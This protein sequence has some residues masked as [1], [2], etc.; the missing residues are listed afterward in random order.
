MDLKRA[1][2]RVVR[3]WCPQ[4]QILADPF[5]LV[6]DANRRLDAIRRLEQAEGRTPIPRWPLVKGAEHLT[7]RQQEQLTQIQAHWPALAQL[8]HLKEDLRALL[9]SATP[10]E[11]QQRWERWLLNA[12]ACDHAEGAVWARTLRRWRH[13]ILGHWT[14]AQRWTNGLIEGYHTKI[15]Q[16]KRLS[17]G[18]RNRDRYRR[19]MFLGFLPSTAIPQLLT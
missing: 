11:A 16:L 9:R 1:Y 13:E 6:Q 10:Q 8:Y 12:E 15:K 14:Q 3:R 4:A 2:A 17:N 5:H 7:P 19:K 18:F